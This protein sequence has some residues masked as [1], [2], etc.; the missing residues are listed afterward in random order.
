MKQFSSFDISCVCRVWMVCLTAVAVLV[1]QSAHKRQTGATEP[2]AS[3]Q[4]QIERAVNSAHGASAEPL[5]EKALQQYPAW[6]KGWWELGSLAYEQNDYMEGR[7]TFSTLAKLDPKAGA[8]WVML[9]LCDFE[10]RDFGLSLLHIEKGRALGF[11]KNPQLSDVARYH[12]ALDL[13]VLDEYEQASYLLDSF[14]REGHR[15]NAVIL[16]EGLAALRIP[17]I[18]PLYQTSVDEAQLNLVQQV[19]EAQY[20]AASKEPEKARAIYLKLLQQYPR[21]AGLHYAYGAQ[22]AR[23]G[24]TGQALSQFQAELQINP[25][26]SAARLE[27]AYLLYRLGR[28]DA[29]LPEAQGAVRLLPASFASHFVLGQIL[30]DQG[31][32]HQGAAELEKSR[33]LQPDSSQVRYA[34]AQVYLRLHRRADALK[35]QQAFRRLQ[36]IEASMIQKGTLPASVFEDGESSTTRPG[37]N[38]EKQ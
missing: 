6:R 5:L 11:P 8:T 24:S 38:T 35:E 1:G 30:V 18:G 23:W 21:A 27:S 32:L 19:G 15:S 37:T 34:L 7:I 22:L 25:D 13:I 20:A 31:H 14:A 26:Q 4:S 16:A 12:Q 2:P 33:D 17:A 28:L 36:P 3:L 10:L 29:A 9:G